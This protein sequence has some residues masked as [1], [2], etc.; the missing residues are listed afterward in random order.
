[1][2]SN[3][4]VTTRSISDNSATG[5]SPGKESMK[6]VGET[7]LEELTKKISYDPE[8]YGCVSSS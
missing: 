5:V 7:S 2:F 1:M 4:R 8:M 3:E 6:F